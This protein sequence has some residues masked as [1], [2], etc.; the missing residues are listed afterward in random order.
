MAKRMA[1][2]AELDDHV[3]QSRRHVVEPGVAGAVP[4]SRRH[5]VEPHGVAGDGP[6]NQEPGNEV[7]DLNLGLQRALSDYGVQELPSVHSPV[8]IHV[9]STLKDKIMSGQYVDL[10]S[11]LAT[12]IE[13]N[14]ENNLSLNC[15]GELVI[16]PSKKQTIDNIESWTDAFIIFSGIY[17]S[18]HPEKTQELLKYMSTIRT[19]AKRHGGLG[20]LSYDQQFRLRMV[21]DPVSMSFDKVDNELWLLYMNTNVL[22]PMPL[23]QANAIAPKKC[24]D[25]N[26]R[27]CFK[28]NCSF[29]HACL[30]CN[31]GHPS[32]YCYRLKG[33]NFFSWRATASQ[34]YP[35][36]YSRP[37]FGARQADPRFT[38]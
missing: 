25:F 5:V 14:L 24:F 1:E 21:S 13:P 12:Q 19:G 33:C 36:P 37:S 2:M 27:Q 26:Y 10:G 18:A 29:R 11:L 7:L 4:Q 6:S 17:L 31:F 35:R 32:R 9:S 38:R 15:S 30:I 3:P 22:Q 20:Y 28:R 16:K 34:G 8:G 23:N